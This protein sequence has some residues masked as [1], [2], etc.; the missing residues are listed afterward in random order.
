MQRKKQN[1]DY[2]LE[3]LPVNPM[4]HNEREMIK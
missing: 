3:D 4:Y 1:S 2:D